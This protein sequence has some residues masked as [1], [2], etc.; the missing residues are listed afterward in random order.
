M[1]R[2]TSPIVVGLATLVLGGALY[3]G[4]RSVAGAPPLGPLLDPV[5]GVWALARTAVPARDAAAE[6]RGL[7]SSVDVRFDDRG[8]PHVFAASLTDAAR[9]MG[10]VHARDRIFQMEIQTQIGRAHV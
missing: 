10:Y 4:T 2:P 6:I 8:V 1:P 3:V 9:A 5:H 7:G